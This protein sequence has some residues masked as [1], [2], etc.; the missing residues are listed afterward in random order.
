MIAESVKYYLGMEL[1]DSRSVAPMVVYKKR[2]KENH[3]E[4]EEST[5]TKS[6]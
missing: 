2:V 4:S 3:C 1:L 5:S 6:E